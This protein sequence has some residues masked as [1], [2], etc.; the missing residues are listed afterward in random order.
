MFPASFDYHKPSS[1]SEALRLLRELPDARLLA[2]GHSLIPAM[3]LRLAAPGALIDIGGLGDLRGVRAE[4][5]ALRIGALTTHA[6]LAASDV[7]RASSP[8]LAECAAQIGDLQV[9]NRGTLG[10]SLAHADPAADLPTAVVALGATLVVEGPGGRREIAASDFFVD[11]FTTALQPGEALVEVRV[12]HDAPGSGA[13]YL[14]HRHPASSYAVVAV[15]A[16]VT[17]AGGKITAADVVI[18]GATVTPVRVTA[19]QAALVGQAPGDAAF[20]AAASHVGA[21]LHDPLSDP[22][23]S[24]DFRRHLAGV[25]TRRALQA[26]AG[27]A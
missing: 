8:L 25:L 23:A 9:R 2:G 3:K 22:Y 27:R 26:A 6:T 12:P 7:V 16:R 10:G 1:L 19:A 13:A 17:V 24:G 18:G 21:A 5:G 14:K 15:A 4:G 20:S 11:L